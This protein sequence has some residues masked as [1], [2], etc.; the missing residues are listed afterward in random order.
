MNAKK[1]INQLWSYLNTA[2]EPERIQ[3]A[4]EEFDFDVKQLEP[5]A[6]LSVSDDIARVILFDLAYMAINGLFGGDFDTWNEVLLYSLQFDKETI[7]YL[8]Y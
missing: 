1:N 2:F 8:N 5:T 3:E 7:N 6:L 4:I